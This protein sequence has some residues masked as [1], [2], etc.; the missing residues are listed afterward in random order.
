MTKHN[1]K[2]LFIFLYVGMPVILAWI[3]YLYSNIP[4][5]P[6]AQTPD[7]M[8]ETSVY[9][10]DAHS[11]FAFYDLPRVSL[12]MASSTGAGGVMKVDLS[13]EIPRADLQRVTDFE[14]RIIE[15]IMLYMRTQNYEELQR[16]NGARE[17]R[18]G[19]EHEIRTGA[20]PIRVASV[21]VREMVF[22]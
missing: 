22:E 2:I 20:F 16:P 7:A 3:G 19:L 1:H 5:V 18:K 13:L 14:P 12:S 4:F 11:V 15:K 9:K 21:N 10:H 17:L 6:K 8:E